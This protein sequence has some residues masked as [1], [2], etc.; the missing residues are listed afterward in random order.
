MVSSILTIM[1]AAPAGAAELVAVGVSLAGD[2]RVVVTWDTDVPT[3]AA[4]VYG[5]TQEYGQAW[6]DPSLATHHE[7]TLESL[8]CDT[9]YHFS[10]VS[11]DADDVSSN[12][13][14]QTFHTGACVTDIEGVAA[15]SVVAYQD[16]AIITY[17]SLEPGRGTLV[18]GETTEF[19]SAVAEPDQLVSF[20]RS[21]LEALTCDTTYHFVG[22]SESA[23]GEVSTTGPQSFTTYACDPFVNDVNVLV[24]KTT[25]TIAWTTDALSKASFIFGETTTYGQEVLAGDGVDLH[26]VDLVGLLCARTY[27]YRIIADDGA[28]TF[29]TPDEAFT[30]APCDGADPIPGL[31]GSGPAVDL[32]PVLTDVA[33]VS[34]ET[35]ASVTWV[36]NG[37]AS[38]SVVW[39]ESN[40]YGAETVSLVVGDAH[41]VDLVDLMCETEYH[42]TAL[43]AGPT[44]VLGSSGN[45][46]FVTGGCGSGIEVEP[47]A[48]R[49]EEPPAEDPPSEEPPSEE[50]PSEEP[51]SEQPPAEEPLVVEPAPIVSDVIVRDI[52][53]ASAAVVW[54][55]EAPASGSVVFGPTTA[56]GSE[57]VNQFPGTTQR[58]VLTGL[59]CGTEYHF[60]P[61]A[62]GADGR[63]TNGGPGSFSTLPC[64]AASIS[65]V[66]VS[67]GLDFFE[68]SWSTDVLADGL[69]LFGE[70]NSYGSATYS[71]T[72]SLEH[73]LLVN[74]LPCGT[75]FHFRVVSDAGVGVPT[76][77]SDNIVATAGCGIEEPLDAHP[78]T[79]GP[80]AE[81][82]PAEEPPAEE[83]P[84][85]D[86]PNEEPPNEEPPTE[87]L[88]IDPAAPANIDDI[89]VTTTQTD[90]VV[91]WTTNV[92]TTTTVVF[93]PSRSYGGEMVV[94]DPRTAHSVVLSGLECGVTYHFRILS[95]TGSG[96]PTVT[97]DQLA[98]TES[99][100]SDV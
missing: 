61:L 43:S 71:P 70:S 89:A 17:G 32:A 98:S 26:R 84:A 40:S 23:T 8:E 42:L 34:G 86:P 30:T 87:E 4:L 85:E 54:S 56:Y 60:S 14:P 93:G 38:A 76:F 81:D 41:R 47:P 90:I 12:S 37:L 24:G 9:D 59:E 74:D 29:W 99:C 53:K 100:D 83:P 82:L 72:M 16:H 3:S 57:A 45:V 66:A 44:G 31:P 51:P 18:F 36:T 7:A 65:D 78:P 10:I 22:L 52:T 5:T 2:D 79:E 21:V 19:G 92:D 25:A 11:T 46:S 73:S 48:P 91:S 97:A 62:S 1:A 27:H 50:P 88:D 35:S 63:L 95:S 49:V 39:G 75:E 80:P 77:T 33:V 96:V 13:G 67:V 15:V 69:I 20:H 94:A 55:T 28:Q 68:I 64:D 6:I 58:V